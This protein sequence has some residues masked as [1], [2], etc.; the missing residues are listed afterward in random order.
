MSFSHCSGVYFFGIL[1]F[2]YYVDEETKFWSYYVF[3]I[4]YVTILNCF[5]TRFFTLSLIFLLHSGHLTEFE[6]IKIGVTD[7]RDE[8]DLNQLI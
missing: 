4:S 7:F 6:D 3:K 2:S 8:K 5:L 1:V